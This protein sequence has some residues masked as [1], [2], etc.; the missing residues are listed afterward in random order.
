MAYKETAEM[1]LLIGRV[2]YGL[3]Q[4]K[5]VDFEYP[6][7]TWEKNA[8]DEWNDSEESCEE[9]AIDSLKNQIVGLMPQATVGQKY[10]TLEEGLKFAKRPDGT[11]EFTFHKGVFTLEQCEVLSRIENLT[12]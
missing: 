3:G 5:Y 4:N 1:S 7:D 11:W 12:K 6:E 9:H 2:H 8:E 10:D